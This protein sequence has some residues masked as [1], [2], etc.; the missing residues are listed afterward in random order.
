M[1]DVSTIN[2]VITI[3]EVVE[4]EITKKSD[5]TK[6]KLIR[7]TD[8]R[9]RELTRFGNEAHD[10]ELA[11]MQGLKGKNVLVMVQDP[12]GQYPRIMNPP[13]ATVNEVTPAT[14]E[15][16][17]KKGGRGGGGGWQPKQPVEL[18]ATLENTCIM[19]AREMVALWAGAQPEMPSLPELR[20]CVAQ[21]GASWY[22]YFSGI[23]PPIDRK[24]GATGVRN[25]QQETSQA[26]ASQAEAPQATMDDLESAQD[27]DDI[28]F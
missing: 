23:L 10:L 16:Q 4:G 12:L 14:G 8:Q 6:S 5:G 1:A 2:E 26:E 3:V 19:S 28:P 7:I 18:H 25:S 17:Q 15:S 24:L 27:P 22:N 20:K 9:G 21:T 11:Y 13:M